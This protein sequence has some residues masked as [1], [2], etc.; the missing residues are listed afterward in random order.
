MQRHIYGSNNVEV[1]ADNTS[2]AVSTSFVE[3][4]LGLLGSTP[5]VATF[6]SKN[7][8]IVAALQKVSR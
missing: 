1:F 3:H 5:R 8:P 7:S 4:W 2:L 6:L